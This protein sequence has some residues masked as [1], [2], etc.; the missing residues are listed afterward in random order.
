MKT[1]IVKIDDRGTRFW[2]KGD[3]KTLHREDGPAV[4]YADGG[5]EWFLNGNL[6]REDGPAFEYASGTKVWY[7][8]NLLHREDGPA[9]E[10]EDGDKYWY[11]NGAELSEEEF[12]SKIKI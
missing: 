4:E 12:N 10:Y 6:H 5:K 7:F 2:Y 8:N 1:Y 9:I 3:G 11:I